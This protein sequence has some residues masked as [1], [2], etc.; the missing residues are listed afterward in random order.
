MKL[1]ACV[2]LL[3]CSSGWAQS[4]ADRVVGAMADRALAEQVA[5]LK[6]DDRIAMYAAIVKAKP[7]DPAHYEVLLASAYVQKSRETTDFSY[8]DRAVS[9]L[10]DV[11]SSD[12]AN[13]EAL[14][15]LTET[16][17]ERHL[18]ATAVESSRRLI[19]I[20]PADPW[21]W[22]TLGD[23]YIEMGEYDKGAEAYQKMVSLRPDLASYNRAA[24]YHFLYG[25]VP[26][27]IAIM[28]KAI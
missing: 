4:N 19:E 13:Y 23:A 22:G 26:G 14:R 6:T 27:A 8:M 3:S 15:L 10:N 28:R 20:S 17:L 2:F 5:T 25:D 11:L 21:N 16:Q 7:S 18:F 12:S 1:L 24:H 9:I